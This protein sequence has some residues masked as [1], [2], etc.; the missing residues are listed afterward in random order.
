[1]DAVHGSQRYEVD[2]KCFV[3]EVGEVSMVLLPT[4]AYLE[5]DEVSASILRA[6]A[7]PRS[8]GE[9][10]AELLAA[11]EVDESV[12]RADVV[13]IVDHLMAHGAIRL[14]APR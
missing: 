9:A 6:F 1:M 13:R 5:L 4:L 2:S 12:V 7:V 10:V 14:C 3:A 11:Y 8:V